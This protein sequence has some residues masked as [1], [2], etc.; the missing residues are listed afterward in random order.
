MS[1]GT[2]AA[3]RAHRELTDVLLWLSHTPE[4]QWPRDL[5]DTLKQAAR[6]LRDGKQAE[7]QVLHGPFEPG[8]PGPG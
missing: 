1:M 5:S 6:E 4:P 7:P 2:E 3:E 8:G